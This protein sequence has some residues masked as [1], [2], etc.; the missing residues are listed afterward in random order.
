MESRG[1]SLLQGSRGYAVLG[2]AWRKSNNDSC[3][4]SSRV[5]SQW[6]LA[7]RGK[8]GRSGFLFLV[9]EEPAME[10]TP[11]QVIGYFNGEQQNLIPLFQ[12][13]YSWD[14]QNWQTLWDDLLGQYSDPDAA[15]FLG[16][17]VSMP[18]RT[19]PVGVNKYLIIDGQQRLTTI[20]LLL[21][22]L[23]EVADERTAGRISD[24]LVNRH[25]EG[26]A[27]YLKMLPTQVDRDCY[28]AL[29]ARRSTT[30]DSRMAQAVKFFIAGLKGKDLDD[31]SVDPAKVFEVLVTRFQVVMINLSDADDPY[32]IFESLNHKGEPLTQA[33]LVRNYVLMKFRH[34]SHVGGEQE[35][36][37]R[38]YWRPLE[39]ELGA[40]LTEFLRHYTL[41]TGRDVKKNAVYG[42]IK[43]RLRQRESEGALKE[44]LQVL[45]STGRHYS[46]FLTP[47]RE[48]DVDLRKRLEA[49]WELK[50]AACYPLL[51]RLY[52]A[53][54]KG[55]L[56]TPELAACCG[57]LESFL[58]RRTVCGVPT[59]SLG[60]IF[61]QLA[62]G[63]PEES[64]LSW[65]LSELDTGDG[66]KRWPEDGEFRQSIV[67]ANQYERQ[68]FAVFLLTRLERQYSHKEPADLSSATIEHIMP[69]TLSEA[70]RA[71]LGPNA[72]TVHGKWLHT[73]GNLTLSAYNPELGNSPF[74]MK[75][76]RFA[77]S[78]LVLNRQISEK[79][80]WDEETMRERALDLAEIASTLWPHPRAKKSGQV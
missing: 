5:G 73:L 11:T 52:A 3:Q 12:R 16:T 25:H 39:D 56:S 48:T 27:D 75:R 41:Q 47:Q 29:V 4:F 35:E 60:R 10:A 13:A 66:G 78:N 54:E 70:W 31:Q 59:N 34:S 63:C 80:K 62:K 43:E 32:L 2:E 26:T 19:V 45:R 69:Q 64:V 20:A 61:A 50:V 44:E 7:D 37:Y 57:Y 23:R 17:I 9:I 40:E 30:N 67:D 46:L 22:A 6:G 71:H 24:Y 42:A 72:M 55:H 8:C 18:A 14:R 51:L 38:E 49:F 77:T 36:I 28:E 76:A 1:F 21:V 58:V 68:K 53:R 74:D 15:H 65:L 79:I 33:D